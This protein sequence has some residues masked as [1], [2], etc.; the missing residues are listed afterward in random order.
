MN[1][2]KVAVV[3]SGTA[4]YA[5]A[6]G[7]VLMGLTRHS[8]GLA[9]ETVIY[10]QGFSGRDKEALEAIRPCR[11]IEYRG[12]ALSGYVES[13][14][15]RRVTTATFATFEMFDHLENFNYVIYLDADI[16]IYRDIGGLIDYAR[17]VGMSLISKNSPGVLEGQL[18]ANHE[19]R[20]LPDFEGNAGVI[21]VGDQIDSRGLK[22]LM[23]KKAVQ[24]SPTNKRGDQTIF[25]LGLF[26]QGIPV[27]DLPAEYNYRGFCLPI[28]PQV[29][30]LHQVYL[31][32]FWNNAIVKLMAP[33]WEENYRLWLEMGGSPYQGEVRF[34][35]FSVVG[36]AP[37]F[38]L[39]AAARIY[40][41]ALNDLLSRLGQRL[42]D[43]FGFE[44]Q[45]ENYC[46][47]LYCGGLATAE[48]H[49]FDKYVSISAE[50]EGAAAAGELW[51]KRRDGEFFARRNP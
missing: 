5:F 1:G 48:I 24:Y 10:H 34:K 47:K 38:K 40:Q 44:F 27:C 31:E 28:N 15:F 14:H 22:E 3:M 33:Q 41:A 26:L 43:R 49:M 25:N 50:G 11:F 20:P 12:E 46:L 51:E 36:E 45:V 35:E 13:E 21:V 7:N 4:D 23:Y 39:A 9:D 16:L 32:K 42:S 6:I 2:K 30:I 8:P 29:R 37:L 19:G 17:P 18:G